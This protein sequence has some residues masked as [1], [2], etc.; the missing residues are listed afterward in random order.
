[1]T[2]TGVGDPSSDVLSS[3]T[4]FMILTESRFNLEISCNY[5]GWAGGGGGGQEDEGQRLQ[6]KILHSI[7]NIDVS[8]VFTIY[9][10]KKDTERK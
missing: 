4:S 10:V 1:M 8:T 5:A 2:Q 3:S 6:T 7:L 9:P